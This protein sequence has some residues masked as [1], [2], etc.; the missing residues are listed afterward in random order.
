LGVGNVSGAGLLTT[1]LY[2]VCV[3]LAFVVVSVSLTVKVTVCADAGV[4]LT[5][6]ELATYPQAEFGAGELKLS[7]GKPVTV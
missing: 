6:T 7:E 4:P 1:M 2:P 5:G 3:M